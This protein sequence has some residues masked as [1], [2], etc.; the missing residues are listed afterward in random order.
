MTSSK[1]LISTRF[2]SGF[3]DSVD[4]FGPFETSK[5]LTR[6][7]D[8]TSSF[9]VGRAPRP[10]YSSGPGYPSSAGTLS[11]RFTRDAS[12]RGF[13]SGGRYTVSGVKVDFE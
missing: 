2:Y 7:V 13:F 10:S 8:Q 5:S 3:Y 6:V 11:I 1:T 9:N 4:I 12:T